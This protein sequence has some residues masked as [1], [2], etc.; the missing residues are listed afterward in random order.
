MRRDY[1]SAEARKMVVAG[2]SNA[3]GMCATDPRNEWVQVVAAGIRD[4]Q[5]GYLEV[6]NNAIPA[7]V[8]SRDAPGY[9]A[10]DL[11][12]TSPALLERLDRDVLDLNPDLVIYAYGMNDARCGHR[13]DSFLSAYDEALVRTRKR[14]PEALVLLVGPYW[15]PQCDDELWG[16]PKYAKDKKYFGMFGRGGEDLITAYSAGIAE[17]A[18][19]YECLFADIY[20]SLRGALW[21]IHEGDNVHFNDVGHKVIGNLVF[22]T[23]AINCSFLARKSRAAFVDGG[24]T[25]RNTGGTN[26]M[27][28]VVR[29]WRYMADD[30]SDWFNPPMVNEPIDR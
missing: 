26:G 1:R 20:P 19:R 2:E 23:L 7:N 8:I 15:V 16:N 30:D 24:M 3:Y 25:L 10:T 17:L 12:G 4:H 6:R 5:D 14:L 13:I 11:P 28:D 9:H 27:P 21:L 18:R 29:T 22:T